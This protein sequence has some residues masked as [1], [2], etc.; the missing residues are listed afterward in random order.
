MKT[1]I[2]SAIVVSAIVL[3]GALARSQTPEHPKASHKRAVTLETVL[4]CVGDNLINEVFKTEAGTARTSLNLL[5]MTLVKYK[6]GDSKR[7]ELLSYGFQTQDL[8][9]GDNVVLGI[10][11]TDYLGNDVPISSRT[12]CQSGV[13]AHYDASDWKSGPFRIAIDGED[14]L[15]HPNEVFAHADQFHF[16]SGVFTNASDVFLTAT[17]GRVSIQFVCKPT[18][19]TFYRASYTKG[20]G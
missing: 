10:T 12:F 11:P 5:L 18:G 20:G 13:T 14:W 7:L 4:S 16:D 17:K 2:A 9:S 1:G 6:T 3:S 8:G 15:L 19:L